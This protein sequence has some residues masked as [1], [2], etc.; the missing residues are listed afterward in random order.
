MGVGGWLAGGV[1]I[2]SLFGGRHSSTRANKIS[3]FS[4][5]TAKY[6]EIV[7]EILGTTRIA[8]NVLYYDDF[9]AHKHSRRHGKGGLGGGSKE[10]YYTYTVATIIGLCEGEINCIKQVWKDQDVK[11]YPAWNFNLFKGTQDQAPWAYLTGKH[12]DKALSYPGLAYVAGVLDLGESSNFPNFNFE[13]AGKLLDTGDGVDV[14]PANY[15]RYVL[16]R[17]GLSSVEVIGLDNYRA[18]CKAADLLISTPGDESGSKTAREVINE[19][20]SLT[21]TFMFW[22]NNSFKIVPLEDRTIGDWKPNKN[23]VEELTAEH[24][25]PQASGALVSYQ[26]KDSSDIYNYFPVEFVDRANGYE[27]STISY[28][29]NSDIQEFGLR[30]APTLSAHYIYTKKRAIQ[31]AEKEARKA[32]NRR[33]KYT[34]KLD[35]SHCLLEVGDIVTITDASCGIERKPVVIESVTESNT[36][37]ITLTAFSM[38]PGTYYVDGK[39]VNLGDQ[40][41]SPT[42]KAEEV[43]RPLVRYDVPAGDTTP[44]I[45]WPPYILSESG[46]E[47]WIGAKGGDGWGGCT[48]LGSDDGT[49]YSGVGECVGEARFGTLSKGVSADSTTLEVSINDSLISGSALNATNGDT[50]C[51]LDGECLSYQGATMLDNGHYQLTDC[52]RGQ[53]GT[54]AVS[55]NSGS[56]FARLDSAFQRITYK[57]SYIGQTIHLKFL[58][59][60]VFGSGEPDESKLKDYT[61]TLKAYP[62]AEATG[63]KLKQV[64]RDMGNGNYD[65]AVS[66][67]WDLTDGT[68]TATKGV[69]RRSSSDGKTYGNWEL[70]GYGESELVAH[71]CVGGMTY[72]FAVA[73][74]SSGLDKAANATIAITVVTP[75][76]SDGSTSDKGGT[77]N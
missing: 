36:G 21:D 37:I 43:K 9:K 75:E 60:N 11:D 33:N 56:A 46:H 4:V 12:P 18:Y 49:N 7:P 39:A 48:I 24:F 42:I 71:W 73:S 63:V 72:Q 17:V 69:W 65:Y 2:G 23:V 30:Q 10:K 67:A 32:K 57:T 64:T 77:G 20:T 66:V 44:M 70:V 61:Y 76:P 28:A 26:R 47:L 8:G 5:S 35:W 53:Y 13:V 54:K 62:K 1:V 27:T 31:L 55:H 50:L 34:F 68:G 25:I 19:I 59:F 40:D 14:N 52:I 15:I 74:D 6:G 29:V 38:P 51:W 16:D 22:S 45:I 3:G 58:S 41:K